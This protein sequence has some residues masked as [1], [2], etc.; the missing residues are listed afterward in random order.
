MIE[1][2]SAKPAPFDIVLV[3]SFSRF[4]RDHFEFEFLA[5]PRVWRHPQ[6]ATGWNPFSPTRNARRN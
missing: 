2:G 1:A 5:G 3:H 4:F 6:I